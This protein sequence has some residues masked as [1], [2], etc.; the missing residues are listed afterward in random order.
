MGT[1]SPSSWGSP[2]SL[3]MNGSLLDQGGAARL[4]K[5]HQSSQALPTVGT[6]LVRPSHCLP[7]PSSLC[8]SHAGFYNPRALFG[9]ALQPLPSPSSSTQ[10]D[11]FRLV[12]G[13]RKCSCSLQTPRLAES[14]LLASADPSL[15]AITT[16]WSTGPQEVQMRC[17]RRCM[18]G[19]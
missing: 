9:F 17:L 6:A 19:G 3:T 14:P 8:W 7:G 11:G 10:Q 12:S 18:P 13:M 5:E 1:G 4:G 15:A 2:E 16:G